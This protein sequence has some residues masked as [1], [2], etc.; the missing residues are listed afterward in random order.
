MD[1]QD[2]VDN[3]QSEFGDWQTP[4]GLADQVCQK[5]KTLGISPNHII[6]P[7][8]GVGNFLQSAQQHFPSAHSLIGVEINPC[9]VTQAADHFPGA[10]IIQ[11]DFFQFRWKE[12]LLG[13][14]DGLLVLGNLPWVTNAAQGRHGSENLPEKWNVHQD[15]GIDAM[16]G[17]GNFDISETMLVEIAGWLRDQ[18]GWI[19]VLCKTSTAQRFLGWL[20]NGRHP[21]AQASLFKINAK[22]SFHVA[23]D[24][25]LLVCSFHG[26]CREYGYTI[27]PSLESQT[28]S[29][30]EYEDDLPIRDPICFEQHRHLFGR[31]V[32]PWRSGIKH[33]C[34]RVMEFTQQGTQIINGTGEVVDIEW[35]VL[36]PLRKGATLVNGQK[37]QD[38]RYVLL[39]QPSLRTPVALLQ[40]TAPRAW[41][42]LINHADLLAQR[43]S[44]IY[45]KEPF[46]IFGVGAYSFAPWKVAIYSLHRSLVFRLVEPQDG[47]PVMMDDT[48]Y[49]LPFHDPDQAQ[50]ALA[51][52]TSRPVLELLNAMIFWG[53][54]RPIKASILNHICLP[55]EVKPYEEP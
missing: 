3:R 29:R 53:E 38:N 10:Q 46:S 25:C 19:A 47:R 34:A 14:R 49:F 20:R 36:Y 2:I 35:D 26:D 45:Q 1:A 52:L 28:G 27:Y 37:Q 42:Y 6:E 44:R 16:T 13:R 41:E 33:D 50:V 17:R 51:H 8:C 31:S 54:K 39:S 48:S 32:L 15:R 18:T 23:V 30:V 7:T 22:R 11:G 55:D 24:A 9:Y 12:I 43:K 5:L 4:Q 21:L 40:K